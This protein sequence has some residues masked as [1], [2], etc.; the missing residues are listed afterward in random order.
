[1]EAHVCEQ[2]ARGHYRCSLIT[3][4]CKDFFL[5]M[6]HWTGLNKRGFKQSRK[7]IKWNYLTAEQT[8][9]LLSCK[10]NTWNI[11]LRGQTTAVDWCHWGGEVL[12]S[13]A[14]C[15]VVNDRAHQ[16][17]VRVC[18]RMQ[19][20][21]RKVHRATALL[22]WNLLSLYVPFCLFTHSVSI[23]LF[24]CVSDMLL[25]CPRCEQLAQSHYPPAV[26][27]TVSE[28]RCLSSG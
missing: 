8:R 6:R 13:C 18:R 1:M 24:I 26:Q 25:F 21:A 4:A 3:V 27:E 19:C 5:P 23:F 17:T 2:L 22:P 10:S 20:P 16:R 11:T 15:Y 28:L 12:T 14:G 9:D 7:E